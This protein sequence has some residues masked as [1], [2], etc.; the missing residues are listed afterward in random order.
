[1]Q[2]VANGPNIPDELLQAHEEGR[3]A[4]FC[5]AGISYPA[6]LPGFKDLVD[7]IYS[8]IG[9]TPDQ[10]EQ[11]VYDQGLFDGTLDLLQ[12][13]VPGQKSTVRRALAHVLQPNLRLRGAK[14]THSAL[15]T[16][17][18]NRE[19]ALRLVTTNFDRIFTRL[20][21][22]RKPDFPSFAAPLLPIPKNSQW[23]G[24]VYLHG[25]LPQKPD[26]DALNRLVL[27][28]GDFGLAYLTER[29]AA[30]FVSELF[31][32]YIVCFVGYSINDPVLRYMMD[33]LAADRM[34]GEAVPVAYAFADYQ[35]GEK[36]SKTIEW[37]SK[38]VTPILY[39]VPIST[40]DHSALHN[41]LKTWAETYRDGISGKEAI[42]G[43]YAITR[44][45]A[46]T[47]QDDFVGRMLWALSHPSGLPARQFAEFDPVPSLDW[48]DAL[49]AERF[50]HS[51]LPQF[52]VTP[53]AGIDE[54]ISFSMMHR[55][56]SYT[57]TPWMM[58]VTQ[59]NSSTQWDNVMF[60]LARWLVRHLD[61][62]VLILWVA[63]N[64]G[65]LHD[66]LIK[67]VEGNL[68]TFARLE[69]GHETH[70]LERIR[71][72]SPRA[73]PRPML[74]PV[75]RL[76]LSDRVKSL[77]KNLDLYRWRDRFK[78]EGLTTFLRLELRE[79]LSPKIKLKEPFHW[80]G[81]GNV[82]EHPVR[83]KQC[84]DW[85]LVLATDHVNSALKRLKDTEMWQEALPALLN[86]FE[87]LLRD[88]LDLMRE[89]GDAKDNSDRSHWNLPSVSP[90]WQNRHHIDWI[91]LIELVRDAW[92]AVYKSGSTN[93][94]RIAQAWWIV[95]Y[96]TFKRLALY[97]AS[98]DGGVSNEI[99]VD[100]L[101]ENGAWWLWSIETRRE[102]LR[103]LV[104][105]GS[106][107]T[108]EAIHRLESAISSGPP[109]S[110]RQGDIEPEHR[111]AL[112]DRS[113]W[114]Y[115]AKLQSSQANLGSEALA[116]LELLSVKY[117]QWSLASNESDEF[118][119]WTSGTGDPGFEDGRHKDV[120][121]RNRA[122]LVA[123]L[124]RTQPPH[125]HFYDDNWREVCQK[126]PFHCKLALA[127]L[128][129]EALW[130]S[131]RWREA[132]QAWSDKEGVFR[133]WRLVA[134]LIQHMPQEVLGELSMSLAW[135]LEAASKVLDRHEDVF[136]E[137]SS[138]ILALSY[139]NEGGMDDPVGKA[140]NHPVGHVTQALLNLWFNREP[141]DGEG[142]P[143]DL[144]PIF[145][146]LCNTDIAKFRH[147][148][149]L[150]TSRLIA[151][152]RIDPRWTEEYVLPLLD[153]EKNTTEARAAW[154]GF[155]WSPRIYR[156]LLVAIKPQLL[157]T[158]NHYDQ[159]GDHA[160][161]FSAFLTYIALDQVD[162]YTTEDFQSAF[163]ALPQVG[164]N[165][166]AQTIAQTIE[167][168]GDQR[169]EY[170]DNRLA[171][172][173]HDLWPK[174]LQLASRDIA[175][176]L[177]QLSIAAR[178]RF[179]AALTAVFDWLQPV[180][181]PDY[182]VHQLWDSGLSQ[183][184]PQDALRLLDAIIDDQPWASEDLERCLTEIAQASP[185]LAEDLRYQRLS[186]YYRRRHT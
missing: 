185:R 92:V 21:G 94:A 67:L 62:P 161:Q 166:A 136:L 89:L 26:N 20:N 27:T 114:L 170:W 37:E 13:R 81:G 68:D 65:E 155:L 147:G 165:E 56:A 173:W 135:W 83:L 80:S 110:M 177:A 126:W 102:T 168:A 52:Q 157:D 40:H 151:I 18:T 39:E 182:I 33:A 122:E 82:T 107:L 112:L 6:G 70:K 17:A 152:Y 64:G 150:L 78:R 10:I 29:W 172:F 3:V 109:L 139:E 9:T 19:G 2:F 130:P 44:P 158:V 11:K 46:S 125:P 28:S 69:R 4:F 123:W 99:W 5:G 120:A 144:E 117:T 154:E 38:G 104:L 54:E 66:R 184:D 84:V 14:D 71:A 85:E 164:L 93:A 30:R 141:N 79:L 36:S 142:L 163:G 178:G 45:S 105:Q 131:E 133:S 73:I 51:D 169:E 76:L 47:L 95:P 97:A 186:Q 115:L 106:N 100:W 176:S 58:L 41:T 7:K 118:S 175:D 121:P 134:P 50:K 16:L 48:L 32:N 183:T 149:V 25:L 113:I 162:S 86:D 167:G 8:H 119:H 132:L 90:H 103:L 57:L 12:R 74:L 15:R 156:P 148:R 31:R 72:Q 101:L 49:A 96:P 61:D 143:D 77:W 91:S 87:Q 63:K 140:I 124:K 75:W 180:E 23:N 34:Q 24:L 145:T 137:M 22:H 43:E 160:G 1:M 153:W 60:H 35:S 59:G 53:A 127:D 138:R 128:A 171:P 181:Y 179:S 116:L 111:Q 55:P 88:A 174:T 108:P 159:L 146:Q 98:Q 129:E 42:V